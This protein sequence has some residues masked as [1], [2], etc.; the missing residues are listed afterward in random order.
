MICGIKKSIKVFEN[1]PNIPTTAKTI[2][3]NVVKV[4][5]MKTLEGNLKLNFLTYY[6]WREQVKWTK[7]EVWLLKRINDFEQ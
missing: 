5:P 6:T 1:P 3:E 2:P 4:S 7:M